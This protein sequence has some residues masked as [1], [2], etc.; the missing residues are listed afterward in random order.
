MVEPW[1][2]DPVSDDE[3]Q[4][5]ELKPRYVDKP[6]VQAPPKVVKKV[7]VEDKSKKPKQPKEKSILTNKFKALLAANLKKH[8]LG[9]DIQDK[10][11][12]L[13]VTKPKRDS[14]VQSTTCSS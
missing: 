7:A 6:A 4:I 12:A 9:K 1:N 13:Y 2:H 14:D 8:N 5:N 3:D 11:T 10:V